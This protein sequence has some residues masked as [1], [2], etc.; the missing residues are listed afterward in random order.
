MSTGRGGSSEAERGERRRLGWA[1]WD[2]EAGEEGREDTLENGDSP[3]G[4]WTSVGEVAVA[5][6]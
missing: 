6:G 2:S 3:V 5:W 1:L 4:D